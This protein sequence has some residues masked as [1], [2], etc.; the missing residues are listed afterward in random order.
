MTY[1]SKIDLNNSFSLELPIAIEALRLK[2]LGSLSAMYQCPTFSKVLC[3]QLPI[4]QSQNDL[5]Y[6]LIFLL[7]SVHLFLQGRLLGNRHNHK[8]DYRYFFILVWNHLA[9]ELA[10]PYIFSHPQHPVR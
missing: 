1:F 2:Y 3:R 6:C 9:L 8:S 10:K 4:S 7:T 5:H